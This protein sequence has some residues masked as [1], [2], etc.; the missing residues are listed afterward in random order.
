MVKL[1]PDVS[2]AQLKTH[3]VAKV[4]PQMYRI[5]Y[6]ETSAV[7]MAYVHLVSISAVTCHWL[8]DPLNIKNTFLNCKLDEKVYMEQSLGLCAQGEFGKHADFKLLL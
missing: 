1:N 2:L 5:D 4:Y 6:Q 3:L 8:L 7:R